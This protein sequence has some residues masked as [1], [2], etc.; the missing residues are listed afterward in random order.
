MV[1]LETAKLFHGLNQD[2]LLGLRR[3]ARE[4]QFP[5]GTQILHEGDM[6]DGVYV[7][8]VGLVEIVHIAGQEARHVFSQLG[9]GEMFGEMAVIEGL[10]R[11]AAA[12]A[13]K[14]TEVYFVP[15][16]EMLT[17]LQHSPRLAFN[18]LKEISLRLREFNQLHLR[19][20]VQAERLAAI[21]NFA[22]SIVHDLKNPLTII[23][24]SAEMMNRE[25][26]K[27]E[28]RALEAGRIKKQIVRIND[29]VGDILEF[30]RSNHIGL[31]LKP[32]SYAEFFNDM[33]P[34]LKAE[35]QPKA[36]SIQFQNEP[37]AVKV[38]VDSHR[39][40]RVFFNLAHNATDVMLTGGKIFLRFRADEKEV[41]TE[42][43]DT[44]PGIAPEISGKLFQAFVTFGKSHGTGLG[45]SI[46]K[47]IIEDHG[48]RIWVRSEPKRGAIFCFAL[49]LAK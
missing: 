20:I 11:S 29:M 2:E 4:R 15:K 31:A 6:G 41:T 14:D 36:V 7:I 3:I 17:L 12:I 26:L 1:E 33:L 35:T 21:G 24:L 46:C 19:E 34:E 5:A 37:P 44:G 16:D 48:G 40:R 10:P 30:T 49:P 18:L 47:K 32:A 38:L 13:A 45:L 22:R 23:S 8:R 28:K 25:N 39:L 9:P 27:P 43:E 42:I